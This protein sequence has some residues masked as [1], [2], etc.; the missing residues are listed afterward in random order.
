M[1]DIYCH[2]CLKIVIFHVFKLAYCTSRHHSCVQKQH[3]YVNVS[4]LVCN[5]CLVVLDCVQCCKV[6]DNC[7]CLDLRVLCSNC[8]QHVCNLV[9]VSSYNA[10]VKALRCDLVTDL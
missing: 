5:S 8:R 1:Q 6:A 9:V 3:C 10:D 4:H 7:A 2:N